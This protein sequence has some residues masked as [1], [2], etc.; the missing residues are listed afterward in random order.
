MYIRIQH[1]LYN[2]NISCLSTA[3]FFVPSIKTYSRTSFT[4]FHGSKNLRALCL[5]QWILIITSYSF[6]I[7]YISQI[8]NYRIRRANKTVEFTIST[9]QLIN[10]NFVEPDRQ[11]KNSIFYTINIKQLNQ[12]CFMKLSSHTFVTCCCARP[13]NRFYF[14]FSDLRPFFTFLRTLVESRAY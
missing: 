8:N 11:L 14:H 2:I 13:R 5:V 6:Y 7:L 4:S 10:I 3:Q 12:L 1:A 9:H